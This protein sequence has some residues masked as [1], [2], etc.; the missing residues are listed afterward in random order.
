MF[1]NKYPHTDFHELNLDWFLNEFKILE[2]KYS[3]VLNKELKNF[4]KEKLHDLF[5]NCTYDADHE[6][7]ILYFDSELI[8]DG[9]HVYND[10]NETM[11]I[12]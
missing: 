8:A 6:R 2:D 3:F 5:V 11:T 4:I 7:A 9:E 1:D 12:I 10:E